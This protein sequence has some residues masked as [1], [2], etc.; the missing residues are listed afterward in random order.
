MPLGGIAPT[1]RCEL[2]LLVLG[3]TLL[4]ELTHHSTADVRRA[5]SLS[6]I[7]IVQEDYY[8]KMS[9]RL[10]RLNTAAQ[11]AQPTPAAPSGSAELIRE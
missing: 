8:T 7:A 11:G 4:N 10:L 9:I 6:E 3:L 5:P 2:L 1:P